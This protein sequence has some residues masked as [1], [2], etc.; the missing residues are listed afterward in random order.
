MS[1]VERRVRWRIGLQ[2]S[3]IASVTDIPD[4]MLFRGL[5]ILHPDSIRQPHYDRAIAWSRNE[6]FDIVRL[7]RIRKLYG[8]LVG[9]IKR[10]RTT[11]QTT[12][13]ADS[14][15]IHGKLRDGIGGRPRG[16]CG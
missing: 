1:G 5:T 10:T 8:Q 11:C 2:R 9:R 16:R 15:R 4:K 14:R 13:W 6:V 3:W 12:G 7:A